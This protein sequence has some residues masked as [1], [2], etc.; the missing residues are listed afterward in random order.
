MTREEPGSIEGKL[1]LSGKGYAIKD[2]LTNGYTPVDVGEDLRGS[3][4]LAV[5]KHVAV[6]GQMTYRWGE[7]FTPV[8]VRAEEIRVLVN[9]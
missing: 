8:R 5:G 1:V 6:T 3:F 7:Y 4:R 2:L 9:Q